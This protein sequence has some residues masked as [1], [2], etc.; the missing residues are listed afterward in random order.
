MNL[1]DLYLFIINNTN[2]GVYG[3][4]LERNIFFCNE[5]AENIT[6]YKKSETIGKSC[7]DDMLD[8]IDKNGKQMCLFGCPLYKVFGEGANHK[9][10]AFLKHKKGHRIPVDISIHP[11]SE[12]GKIIGCIKIFKPNSL[13][14]YEDELIQ[15]LS[16][17]AMNDQLTAIP[18]R[19][20]VESYIEYKLNELKMFNR[21]FCIIFL[22]IDNFGLFNDTYGHDIG[23]D[24]LKCVAKSI[25]LTSKASDLIGRWGGEEFIG[26]FEIEKNSN[27]YFLAEKVRETI[28]SI[29][30]EVEDS[31]VNVTASLGVTLGYREDTI[32]G[33]VKR[34]D[35]LMY[36]SK[37]KG[38]NCVTS[39]I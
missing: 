19:A 18:N 38:K 17:M 34:A 25:T 29:K 23:D 5:E 10:E 21:K 24:V 27:A 7:A 37:N 35:S 28:E 6:G 15:K 9:D 13:N 3:I 31:T 30:I 26:V 4:G 14:C 12:E 36:Q 33:I 22:D 8:Y 39:D 2:V 16:N 20:K 11:L 1:E 32:S